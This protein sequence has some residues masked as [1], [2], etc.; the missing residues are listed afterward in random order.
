MVN[1]GGLNALDNQINKL[2]NYGY[3]N[4]T[5]ATLSRISTWSTHK[6]EVCGCFASLCMNFTVKSSSTQ[7]S[8]YE[9]IATV[10]LSDYIYDGEVS[11]G[12]SVIMNAAGS[13]SGTV[14]GNTFVISI[15]PDSTDN[16]KYVIKVF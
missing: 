7:S 2:K 9:T 11:T 10:D 4:F 14:G 5:P 6:I 13:I 1:S 3:I 12:A 15:D 8:G 16:K